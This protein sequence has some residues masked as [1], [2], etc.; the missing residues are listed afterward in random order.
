MAAGVQYRD[1]A[2]GQPVERREQRLEFQ[3]ARRRVVIGIR[4]DLEAGTLEQ[5]AMVFPARVADPDLCRRAQVPEEIGADLQSAR[6]AQRLHR[7]HALVLQRRRIRPEHQRLHGLVV[8]LQAVDRQVRPGRA[9]QRLLL[10]DL[11]HAGEQRHLAVLVVIHAHAEVDLVR[12]L[13]RDVE[14]GD[15]EDRVLRRHRHRGERG[16]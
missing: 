6:A 14:L 4:I 9:L 7:D 12:V 15:A 10:L 8:G 2:G 3:S 5:R 16:G 13:V 11:A 1:R